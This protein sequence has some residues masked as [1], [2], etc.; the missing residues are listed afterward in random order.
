MERIAVTAQLKEGCETRAR[1]L[2]R[3]GPPFDPR[4][5]GLRAHDVY[6]GHELVVF[7]FEG[8][9][10]EETLS[11]IVNDRLISGAFSAWAPLLAE[12]PRIALDSYHW[13]REETWT[14]S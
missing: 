9:G 12:Q 4:E 3:A 7:V 14:R 5:A 11:E 10:V 2:L 13:D 1:D 6:V 8:G